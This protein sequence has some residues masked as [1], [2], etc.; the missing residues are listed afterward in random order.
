MSLS[1]NASVLVLVCSSMQIFAFW[2]SQPPPVV[3][4]ILQKAQ[5]CNESCTDNGVND[6][7]IL[8]LTS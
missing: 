8:S 6:P 4:G 2:L 3:F 7:A 5:Q 1:E